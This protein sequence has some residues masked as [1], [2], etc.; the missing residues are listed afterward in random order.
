MK[1]PQKFLDNM[2]VLLK[3]DYAKFCK[4]MEKPPVSGMRINSLKANAKIL[5]EFD[6]DK[7]IPYTNNGYVLRNS[8]IGKHPY[9]IAGLVYVQEPSSMIPVVASGLAKE[10]NKNLAVLDLCAAPGGKTG[11]IAEILAGDG[12]LVSNEIDTKRVRA[13]QGNIERLGYTN[14]II[15]NSTPEKLADYLS[16][17]FDYIFVDAPCGGEGMFRKDSDTISEWSESRLKSNAERQLDILSYANRMLKPYGKLIYSTCTY[18]KIEDEDV[19]ENFCEKYN[20]KKLSPD[21]S[22]FKYTTSHFNSCCRRAYPHINNG[23]GQFVCVL[24]KSNVEEEKIRPF[25][26]YKMGNSELKLINSYINDTFQLNFAPF[27]T[28]IGNN[29]CLINQNLQNMLNYMQKIPIINAGVTVCEFAKDRVVPH[30]NM[31]LAYGNL[32]NNKID[33]ELK[34]PRLSK[35]LH[36]EE[37]DNINNLTGYVCITVNKFPI[38]FCKA[39]GSRLKN[40]FPK[41]LRI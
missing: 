1:L 28:K 12:V 35:F 17:Q 4:A 31:F 26:P 33:F 15:T 38:G 39:S 30:N 14:V 6:V 7:K 40:M 5:T 10:E 34:D 16:N 11:Q 36:G 29:Y 22:I 9:H 32:A 18:S 27:Y 24:Q 3:D 25:K 41:G 19:V 2:K 8:K 37:L 20:Y 13:L 23:E 21:S